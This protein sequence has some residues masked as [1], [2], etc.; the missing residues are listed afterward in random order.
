MRFK[1]VLF[2][3]MVSLACGFSIG[4]MAAS[5]RP[6]IEASDGIE[7]APRA[8]MRGG[9]WFMPESNDSIVTRSWGRDH[10]LDADVPIS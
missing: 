8:R 7:V 1:E 3:I 4:W 10:R 6:N 5:D 2:F 9:P